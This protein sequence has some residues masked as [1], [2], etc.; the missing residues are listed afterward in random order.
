VTPRRVAGSLDNGNVKPWILV[1]LAV[2]VSCT[3]AGPKTESS[4]Q[5]ATTVLKQNRDAMVALNGYRAE[6]LTTVTYDPPHTRKKYEFATLTSEKPL[7][8]RYDMWHSET[9]ITAKPETIS[10][11]TFA[12]DGERQFA[13]FGK[14]YSE[15]PKEG[16]S[17]ERMYTILEPWQGFYSAKSSILGFLEEGKSQ[18][19]TPETSLGQPAIVDGV[20]CDAVSVHN[21]VDYEGAKQEYQTTYYFGQDD[22]LVRRM[23]EH[24]TFDG[25]GGF[26]RDSTIRNID[27]SPKIDLTIYRY[28]PP[29]GVVVREEMKRPELLTMG[30]KAPDFSAK[31]HSGKTIKLSDYRGKVVVLDFWASWCGPCRESMPHTEEVAKKLAIGGVPVVVFAVDDGEPFDNFK[32]WVA[33]NS[34][35]YP[36]LVF[37]HAANISSE[38]YNVS[39]I[40]TQYIIDKK[41]IVRGSFVGFGG[42]TDELEVAIRAAAG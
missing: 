5:D 8:M 32:D 42:P 41:G 7:K 24:V 15:T 20:A 38:L 6:C 33:Q 12:C 3:N 16:V 37:A 34:T 23:V 1:G 39:G 27:T 29:E 9:P 25:K 17:A 13:Q 35:K 2:C 11:I 28:T 30:T 31:D 40:P 26:T 10:N 14:T 18:G 21:V 4:A 19:Q 22:H 36:T